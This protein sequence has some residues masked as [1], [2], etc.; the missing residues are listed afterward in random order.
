VGDITY[1]QPAYSE[2]TVLIITGRSGLPKKGYS[3]YDETQR[4]IDP[5]AASQKKW[6][7]L[8]SEGDFNEKARQEIK[9]CMTRGV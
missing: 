2:R 8:D 4:C 9:I 5:Q 7:T 6:L 3:H 1:F